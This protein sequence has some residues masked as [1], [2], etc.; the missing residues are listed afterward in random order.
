VIGFASIPLAGGRH[1]GNVYVIRALTG[2]EALIAPLYQAAPLW[3]VTLA[4][5]SEYQ[6]GC[7][8][9]GEPPTV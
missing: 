4:V 6:P 2:I 3:R 1:D 5:L 9:Y 7:D 8:H